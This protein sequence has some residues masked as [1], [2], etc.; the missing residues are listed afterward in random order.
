MQDIDS[1]LKDL[2]EA[3]GVS[4]HEGEVRAVMSRYLPPEAQIKHDNLGSV[5]ARLKGR[6]DEPRVMLAAHMDEIG[7]M[8]T[9]ITEKGFL[10]FQPIG[11]W[12]DQVLLAQRVEV[13]GASGAIPGVV[14]SKPP[15]ILDDKSKKQVMEKKDMFI[16]IGARDADHAAK[17]GVRHGDPVVPWS[18]FQPMS[19]PDLLMGKAWDDRV[20]CAAVVQ[21]LRELAGSSHPNAVY[22][23]GTVQEEV[24]MRGAKTSAELVKPDVCLV[25]ESSIAGDVPGSDADASSEELGGGPS[26]V[27]YDASMIPSRGLR[28]LVLDTA[29]KMDI[30][31]QFTHSARGGTDGGRI[32]LSAQGVPSLVLGVP[33]R[34]IH[35]HTG[36]IHRG[37]FKRLVDLLKAV[38]LKLDSGKVSELCTV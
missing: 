33:T 20:G 23:V 26:I 32:H 28:D 37:D 36:I 21:V 29:E 14:G 18:P 4:G 13:L 3:A 2:S 38:I 30:K 10:R 24:G 35:S 22:G 8:V 7:F 1:L 25:V 34:Y 31:I 6:L 16:D 17:M 9:R 19:N 5:V 15:H 11:G 27:L 12:W